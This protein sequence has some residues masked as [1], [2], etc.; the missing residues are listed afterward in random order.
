MTTRSPKMGSQIILPSPEAPMKE[1]L[2]AISR[3]DAELSE[4]IEELDDVVDL[5][6]IHGSD[7]N[8]NVVGN[9][10]F[11]E[12]GLTYTFS[13]WNENLGFDGEVNI[14]SVNP[15]AGYQAAEIYQGKDTNT[16]IEDL[17][18]TGPGINYSLQFWAMSSQDC[19][20]QV[21]QGGGDLI[22]K[23]VVPVSSS[24]WTLVTANF[25]TTGAGAV[26]IR[27]WGPSVKD[28]S[29]YY[30]DVLVMPSITYA[31]LDAKVGQ[32]MRV[33]AQILGEW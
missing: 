18:S 19:Q 5:V 28:S 17:F 33:L 20:Y 1:I 16:Y 31:S 10:G 21:I 26:T 32:L 25:T 11:E 23:T 9:P 12:L 6:S 15:H 13:E 8:D 24:A 22:A 27:L 7:F 2:D 4:R 29:V 3:R 14:Y 30:D